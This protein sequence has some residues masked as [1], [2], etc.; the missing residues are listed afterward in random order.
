M[1]SHNPI[2]SHCGT[3]LDEEDTWHGEVSTGDCDQSEIKCKNLDCLK[4]FY[5]TC[6]HEVKFMRCDEDGE[7][8]Y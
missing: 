7:E 3:E 5:T 8:I 1:T 4:V 6:V 2:C